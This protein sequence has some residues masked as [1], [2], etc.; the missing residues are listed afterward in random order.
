M[1]EGRTQRGW[2]IPGVASPE[3]LDEDDRFGESSRYTAHLDRG[4]SL[5]DQGDYQR[6][7][8]SAHQAQ[9]LRPDVPDA[10]M[11]MAAIAL[12]EGD[13]E[14]SL[15]WYE[16]AIET[17]SDYVDAQI[18]AA[19]IL[20]YDLDDPKRAIAR[21]E[22]A[23]EL[24]EATAADRLD[25]A[26][27]E[28][29][30]LLVLDEVE[31]ASERFAALPDVGLL[32]E[33]LDPSTDPERSVALVSELGVVLPEQQGDEPDREELEHALARFVQL[34]VRIARL[35]V[36]LG[37]PEGALPWLR[38]LL[39]RFGDDPELWYLA[40]EAAF[41]AGDPIAAANAALKVMQM[42]A[43]AGVPEWLPKPS[44]L[45]QQVVELLAAC[46][47]PELS[48]LARE[49]G[50]VMLINE[51]PPIEMVVEGVDPRM[52]AM[53]LASRGGSDPS[54]RTRLTGLAIYRR[55]IARL[56]RDPGSL[57]REIELSMFD[58]LAAFFGFDDRRRQKLGLPP[59]EG[60]IGASGP[61]LGSS[62]DE[63]GQSPRLG[64]LGAMLPARD[65]AT[66]TEGPSEPTSESAA[67]ERETEPV[68]VEASP[69]PPAPSR[70]R[71][72][73]KAS[74]RPSTGRKQPGN[75]SSKKPSKQPSKKKPSKKRASK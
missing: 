28:V 62:S 18:A 39:H 34:A 71:E 19:Q 25:L 57:R 72:P 1:A 54:E 2:Y 12:A 46:P 30:A 32:E 45:H 37:E 42:D 24:D 23:R 41:L 27:L 53:A 56:V 14:S 40:N 61:R 65:S 3:N 43:L 75:Q 29:E 59:S 4:W 69:E 66:L 67:P 58:E 21:A 20:L 73:K 38:R 68:A 49:P 55:N 74:S 26:L 22:Q 33:L 15:E 16:R 64:K 13:P 52:R 8:S 6:A 51:A 10:A 31:Q 47:D 48:R 11:L 50:F 7:R 9:R 70:A 17:D 60:F 35:H 5:L 63:L 36:D 44:E